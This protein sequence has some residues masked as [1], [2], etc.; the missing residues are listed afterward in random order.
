LISRQFAEVIVKENPDEVA[1]EEIFL[2]KNPTTSLKL[3]HAR[4]G[5]ITTCLQFNLPI[6]EYAANLIKKSICGVGRAEKQQVAMMV[7][8]LLPKAEFKYDDES[9]ALAVAITHVNH[10]RNY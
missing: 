1:I 10:K 6:F 3:G 7:K 4:G 9:D 5:I 8:V 2:N